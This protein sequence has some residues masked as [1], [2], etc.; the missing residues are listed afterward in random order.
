MH[1][2]SPRTAAGPTGV[3]Q[4]ART[5]LAL[6]LGIN[7]FNYIDRYLLAAVEPKVCSD[8]L[9]AATKEN[10]ARMGSLVTVFT[11][12]YML[13]APLF[14]WLADR[15]SRWFLAGAAVIVWS[16]A[17]GGAGL[18]HTFSTLLIMRLFIGIG[19]AGY[20]PAA[21]TIISDMY[22]VERRGQVLAWF[23]MAIP[24]GSALG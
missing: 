21:P 24:V 22:P 12:S 19:E 15:I 23:Y 20:G 5:A 6:L 14:G 4:G 9:G 1:E 11:V 2:P 8:L 17:S 13:A 16:L 10:L 3:A 7:L 18:G